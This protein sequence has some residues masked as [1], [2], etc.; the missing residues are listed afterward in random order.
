MATFARFG[1]VRRASG[2]L[3]ASDSPGPM[4]DFE[5]IPSGVPSSS[6][7]AGDPGERGKMTLSRCWARP[8][9]PPSPTSVKGAQK[10]GW[11]YRARLEAV[12]VSRISAQKHVWRARISLLSANGVGMTEIQRRTGKGPECLGI[13]PKLRNEP[14]RMGGH[15]G[16][17]SPVT[18]RPCRARRRLRG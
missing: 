2:P 10:L 3:P 1:H 5:P 15:H 7:V 16:P 17:D 4:S 14:L 13:G 8:A 11:A 9:Q 18:G 12:I 6:D